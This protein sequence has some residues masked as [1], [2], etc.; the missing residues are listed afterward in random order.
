MNWVPCE[1]RVAGPQALSRARR[2]G[3]TA[4]SSVSQGL[5]SPLCSL[6]SFP[7]SL[8]LWPHALALRPFTILL[9]TRTSF[10]TPD[11]IHHLC[12]EWGFSIMWVAL[13]SWVGAG[14]LSQHCGWGT[15]GWHLQSHPTR[16]VVV[17]SHRHSGRLTM[18]FSLGLP[19]THWPPH[20]LASVLIPDPW[21]C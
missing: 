21:F 15:D 14:C 20:S 7:L 12:L 10:W 8:W 13:Q 18:L 11:P 16:D 17:C 9:P 19:G 1:W 3:N 5:F 6:S 4:I 2:S